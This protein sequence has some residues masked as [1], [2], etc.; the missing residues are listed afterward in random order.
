MGHS[1]NVIIYINPFPVD[2]IF[3][4]VLNVISEELLCQFLFNI[5]E[6]FAV[7]SFFHWGV[8]TSLGPNPADTSSDIFFL[9][10]SWGGGI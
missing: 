5:S 10:W 1:N 7:Q 3:W 8:K 4:K 6:G 2:E 9:E